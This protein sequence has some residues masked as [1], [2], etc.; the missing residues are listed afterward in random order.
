MRR[1]KQLGLSARVHRTVVIEQSGTAARCG[2]ER[3][4]EVA[5]AN[6]TWSTWSSA[7]QVDRPVPHRLK[8]Q[9]PIRALSSKECDNM[10]MVKLKSSDGTVSGYL[11]IPK[12][13]NGPG[14][15]V[16]HAWWGLTD[17]LKGLCDRLATAGF[18]A[19]APDLYRGATAAIRDEAKKLVSK[20]DDEAAKRDI[21]GSVRGLQTHPAVRGKRLGVIGF[22]LGAFLGLGLVQE[23]PGDVAAVVLFYGT[24]EGDYDTAKLSKTKA[25]FLGHFAETDEFESATSVADLEKLLHTIGKDVTFHAY[26]GTTHWFFEEDRADSYNPRAAEVAWERTIRFLKARLSLQG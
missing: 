8:L 19:F 17:F 4:G 26:P 24:R 6:S 21:A 3:R 12:K 14:V 13:G 22:S 11:A 25:A 16:L 1:L 23:F 5:R 9:T 15:L 10:G 20:L 18:V 7:R 2:D